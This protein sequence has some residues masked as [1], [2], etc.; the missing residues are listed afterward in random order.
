M[1]EDLESEALLYLL[2]RRVCARRPS[3]CSSG[4]MDPSHVLAAMGIDQAWAAG[5]LRMSLGRTTTDGDVDVAL[6]ALTSA[7]ETLR[8]RTAASLFAAVKVLVAMSGGVDSSVAAAL[9][10]GD[11]HHVV[12]VTMRL[13]GGESDT[14]C[15]S[16]ADVDDARR[17]AQQLDIDHL[18]FNFTEDFERHV[19]GPYV[20]AHAGG[21]T[22]NPCIECNRRIK[23]DRLLRRAD[24]LGFDA[25]ATGHHAR[26]ARTAEETPLLQRCRSRQGPELRRAH[27]R[28]RQ[29]ASHVLPRW[30]PAEGGC[31]RHRRRPRAAHSRQAGQPGRLLH[32]VRRRPSASSSNEDC[33]SMRRG[34]GHSW[35]ARREDRRHR[36]GDDR[37]AQGP[38]TARRRPKRYVVGVDRRTSTVVVGDERELLVESTSVE[39]VTWTRT[40]VAGPAR[41]VLG[42]RGGVRRRSSSPTA[43]STCT[44]H[45]P[46]RRVAPGQS[47]VFYD[48][49]DRT[50]LGGGTAR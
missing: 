36:A 43:R 10:A 28:W 45:E 16:V 13:W 14:G 38:R 22:P 15:C 18:V 20:D 34:D 42:A 6:G 35:R 11:G 31:P 24:V 37:P 47:V 23:F 5:A 27:A 19:V 26:I 30:R 21:T 49:E 32:H 8:S 50:V 12:G 40:P 29:P 4:A 3:A 17:V 39:H 1:F 7:V 2:V 25:V 44:W 46:Q 41:P 48:V 33:R 9:L